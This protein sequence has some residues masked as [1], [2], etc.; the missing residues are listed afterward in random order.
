MRKSTVIGF[1]LVGIFSSKAFALEC[2]AVIIGQPSVPNFAESLS[3]RLERLGGKIV[4]YFPPQVAIGFV[5]E[6]VAALLLIDSVIDTVCFTRVNP[7]GWSLPASSKSGLAAWNYFLDLREGLIQ[8]QAPATPPTPLV[9]DNRYPRGSEGA[10]SGQTGDPLDCPFGPASVDPGK[11]FASAYMI[12]KIAVG[13]FLLESN[14]PDENWT[15]GEEQTV[16]NEIFG[17]TNRLSTMAKSNGVNLSWF[18]EFHFKVPTSFEPIQG[19]SKPSYSFPAGWDFAWVGEALAHVGFNTNWCGYYDYVNDLRARMKTNWAYGVF[20]VRDQN[21]PDHEFTDGDF[22]Y[23]MDNSLVVMTYNNADWAPSGMDFVFQHE[24]AHTC[25]AADEYIASGD[26]DDCSKLFG[27][28]GVT[29]GNCARCTGAGNQADCVMRSEYYV[30]V[31]CSFT[32]GQIGWNDFDGDGP[33]DPIDPNTRFWASLSPVSP[34]GRVSIA[35]NETFLKSIAVTSDNSDATGPS[36]FIIWD[37]TNIH[38][39]E[40]IPQCCYY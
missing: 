39:A 6:K 23:T 1:L 21:D 5:P 36:G 12:G 30:T 8:P 17:A 26:C 2:N 33:N 28:I 37:A 14:G 11:R 4:H 22:A 24:T 3:V 20:I 35:L 38:Y 15:A 31:Y 27:Y 25:F 10:V 32:R 34:G 16:V 13:I 40:M 18:Y 9:N 19:P 7:D 29:N